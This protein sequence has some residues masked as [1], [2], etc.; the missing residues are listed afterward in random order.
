MSLCWWL[1][2]VGWGEGARPLLGSLS[3]DH[4]S[5][6]LPLLLYLICLF[7]FLS[8]ATDDDLK[9]QIENSGKIFLFAQ[10]VQYLSITKDTLHSMSPFKLVSRLSF[11]KKFSLQ[12]LHF[13]S[14]CEFLCCSL[15]LFS[16]RQ[17]CLSHFDAIP[18]YRTGPVDELRIFNQMLN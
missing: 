13:I 18:F 5:S 15:L 12:L 1:Y 14:L 10:L 3:L 16:V 9:I 8:L 4:V 7:L 2:S 6:L 17:S 11:H